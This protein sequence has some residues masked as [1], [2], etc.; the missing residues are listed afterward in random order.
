MDLGDRARPVAV[1]GRRG[2]RP[3]EPVGL[4]RVVAGLLPRERAPEEVDEEQDLRGAEDQR[5]DGDELVDGLEV[6]QELVLVGI[7]DAPEVPGDPDVVHREEHAVIAT[8]V[9]QKW[10]L[11][12]VSFIIRPN[13]FGNQ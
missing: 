7:V 8:K 9:N 10:A 5:A 1:R 12:S 2:G 3:L 11:P 6:L 13:I 4:P